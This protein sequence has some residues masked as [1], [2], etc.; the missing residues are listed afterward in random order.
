MS[1]LTSRQDP[2][3]K[4]GRSRVIWIGRC[5]G[6]RSSSVKR[7]TAT[8]DARMRFQAEQFLHAD[9]QCRRARAV[10][11]DGMAI[12]GRRFEVR[13]RLGFQSAL[14]VPRQQNVQSCAQVVRADIG[15]RCLAGQKRRQPID[16]RL[17]RALHPMRSGQLL[18]R[19]RAQKRH[20]ITQLQLRFRPR[21]APD[22]EAAQC[23]APRPRPCRGRTRP[24]AGLRCQYDGAETRHAARLEPCFGR[25]KGDLVRRG[26]S[27]AGDL[28]QFAFRLVV[29]PAGCALLPPVRP[30]RRRPDRP[31]W[32]ARRSGRRCA[33]RPLA[34]RNCPAAPRA[35]AM[36]SGKARARRA[37]VRG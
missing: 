14:H 5:A 8:G 37:A 28:L 4:P 25:R 12:A 18:R 10:I 26:Q 1:D 34:S 31:R 16:H 3:Q 21:Q 15:Q 22:A 27:I 29:Q 24:R 13:R 33:P 11:A 35:L 17:L 23:R 32:P 19:R 20:A 6:D 2:A 36:R 7:Q 30:D 9:G